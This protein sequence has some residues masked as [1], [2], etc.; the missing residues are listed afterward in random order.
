M[1]Y[2]GNVASYGG[3][4]G[5]AVHY[6]FIPSYTALVWYGQTLRL[7]RTCTH[8]S[9]H[10]IITQHKEMLYYYVQNALEFIVIMISGKSWLKFGKSGTG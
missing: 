1:I 7:D 10:A 4:V 9:G 2:L 3:S 5:L 6:I 8:G